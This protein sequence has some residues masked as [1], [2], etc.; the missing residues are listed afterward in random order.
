MTTSENRLIVVRAWQDS[1]R[2]IIR[3]L[4]STDPKSPAVE[5]VFTDIEAAAERLTEVL[6]ELRDHRLHPA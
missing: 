6:T 1:D 3:L 2:L 5:A 4:V